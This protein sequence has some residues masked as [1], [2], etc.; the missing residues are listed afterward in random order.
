MSYPK[1]F[2]R[3]I[4]ETNEFLKGELIGV[5]NPASNILLIG[6]EPAI[7]KEKEQ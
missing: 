2:E 6:K 5:G 4:K 7:P 1:E 3:L